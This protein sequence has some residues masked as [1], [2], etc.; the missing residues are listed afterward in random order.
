M[1][2]H[3]LF[4]YLFDNKGQAEKQQEHEVANIQESEKPFHWLHLNA[5]SPK[6]RNFL[7]SSLPQKLDPFIIDALLADE[8]RPRM[9]QVGDGILLILRGVNLNENSSPEDMVSI[10]L[11]AEENRLISV[12]RRQLKAVLDIEERF[13]SGQGAQNIGD[14]ICALISRLFERME[15]SLAA[16]DEQVDSV[17]EKLLDKADSSLREDIINIRKQAIM[18]KRYMS[19]QK[20]AIA[21]L[22][23]SPPSWMSEVHKRHLHEN[24]NRITRYVEDLDAIRERA[25]I[26][27]DEISNIL[28]DRLNQNMYTLSVVAAIFLPL[29]FL[30]GLLGVNIGGIP[31]T[32]NT[33]AFLFF[34]IFLCVIILLQ[35]ILFKKMKWF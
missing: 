5:L 35:V 2:D 30:T 7:T 20:D 14:L 3:I 23:M 26:I 4:S 27:K 19:P 1:S 18:F 12:R 22:C 16:L 6:T 17:E 8:T 13:A 21:Q 29:G 31:G 33:H 24:L 28:S 9:T 32:E 11:W 15:P 10:R 25:Q 34:N